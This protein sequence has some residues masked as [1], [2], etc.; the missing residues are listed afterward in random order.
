MD[1][2]YY[3]D[4]L[5]DISTILRRGFGNTNA[6]VLEKYLWIHRQYIS[7]IK[8]F[9]NL[10]PDHDYRI[11]NPDHY[12]AVVHLPKLNVEAKRAK[13]IIAQAKKR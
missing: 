5:R 7:A 1:D 6:G 8:Q 13:S 4:Y 9:E 3:S 2:D 12:E 11:N 10:K